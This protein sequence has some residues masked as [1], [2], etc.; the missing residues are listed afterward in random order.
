MPWRLRVNSMR[1]TVDA[2]A[3]QLRPGSPSTG[4]CAPTVLSQNRLWRYATRRSQE[5]C[6]H[7]NESTQLSAHRRGEWNF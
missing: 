5:A 1:S 2:E 3:F 7:T 4:D 6:A